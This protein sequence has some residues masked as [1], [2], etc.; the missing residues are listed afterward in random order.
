MVLLYSI[1]AHAMAPFLGQGANQAIQDAYVLAAAL[2]SI[3][4]KGN[5]KRSANQSVSRLESTLQAIKVYEDIRRGPTQALVRSSRGVGLLETQGGVI[6]TTFRN[7]A[8]AFAG[9]TGLLQAA[10]LSAADPRM[11]QFAD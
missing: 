1:E 2:A 3:G 5:G 8:F 6:G 4:G 7:N 10:F 11:G 9:G